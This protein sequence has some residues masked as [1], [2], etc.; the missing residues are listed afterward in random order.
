MKSSLTIVSTPKKFLDEFDS[1]QRN[2]LLNWSTIVT[3]KQ[4]IIFSDDSITNKIIHEFGCKVVTKIRKSKSGVP[5]ISNIFHQAQQLSKTQLVMYTN[6][7]MIYPENLTK[8]IKVV[9]RKFDKFLIVGKRLDV[10]RLDQPKGKLHSPY[11]IDYF[12]FP[13]NLSWDMP[14]FMIA[15]QYWDIWTLRAALDNKIPLIDAT[16]MIKAIH[17]NHSYNN[18]KGGLRN[19]K[20][21]KEVEVNSALARGKQASIQ[22]ANYIL[23]SIGVIRKPKIYIQA[24]LVISKLRHLVV[25]SRIYNKLLSIFRVLVWEL[26]PP[27]QHFR[28]I[29]QVKFGLK[30]LIIGSS[31]TTQYG[32]MS[33]DIDVLDITNKSNWNKYFKVNYLSNIIS[34]HVFEH[35]N[36][37]GVKV[38]VNN[39]YEFLK[40]GGILRIAVPDGYNPSS[41]YI[42]HV[43]PHGP[44]HQ[45]HQHK[46]LYNYQTLTK[47]LKSAGFKVNL[48][49]YYDMN[50]EFHR[51]PW[52]TKDGMVQRSALYDKRNLNGHLNY[53]S[54]IIDAIKPN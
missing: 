34:E 24:R 35:L 22:D 1:I 30:R 46:V 8:V 23:T 29:W 44:E 39:C 38:A 51:M 3:P 40:P 11:G 12:I 9:Q 50:G 31:N 43:R 53:T 47:L 4:V 26:R 32:W 37:S 36:K 10:D 25:N 42:N 21:L 2:S 17:Q 6:S 41:E 16:Y 14:D 5:L 13:K 49:E 28:Y 20:F 15:R 48:L 45:D 33:S 19:K 52:S 18:M 27:I 7:D 54:L